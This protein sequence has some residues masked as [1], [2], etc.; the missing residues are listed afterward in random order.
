MRFKPKSITS[1]GLD[2][3]PL[4]NSTAPNL[5]GI[6][7]A[8][9]VLVAIVQIRL[10]EWQNLVAIFVGL[11]HPDRTA[12]ISHQLAPKG[13]GDGLDRLTGSPHQRVDFPA[14]GLVHEQDIRRAHDRVHEL[15]ELGQGQSIPA[16]GR[17][18]VDHLAAG[19]AIF[20]AVEFI[21]I[22]AVVAVEELV[23][24]GQGRSF[25]LSCR[26]RSPGDRSHC[27][28]FSQGL[29]RPRTGRP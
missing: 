19:Q 26:H 20:Q 23:A 24:E 13:I 28:E 1:I 29:C 27:P 14:H 5:T 7:R 3:R 10:G 17:A 16:V 15:I 22:G 6:N 11:D 4:T 18:H 8:G 2:C 21:W 9:D 12:R 25:W